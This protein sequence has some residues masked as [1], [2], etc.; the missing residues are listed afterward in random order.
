MDYAGAAEALVDIALTDADESDR[1]DAAGALASA[2]S[3]EFASS[4]LGALRRS[5]SGPPRP[6]HGGRWFAQWTSAVPLAL[7]AGLANLFLHGTALIAIRRYRIGIALLVAEAAIVAALASDSGPGWIAWLLAVT[8]LVGCWLPVKTLIER[9]SRLETRLGTFPGVLA[10]G[11][12][13]GSAFTLFFLVH[14]LAHLFAG[15]TRTAIRIFGLQLIAVVCGGLWYVDRQ[16]YGLTRVGPFYQ[17]A[18]IALWAAT[19]LWDVIPVAYCFLIAPERELARQRRRD[20]CSK[21][22]ANVT[23][24]DVLLE[25]AES[26]D[27]ADRTWARSVVRKCGDCVAPLFWV[28]VLRARGTSTPKFVDQALRNTRREETIRGIQALWSDGDPG[29]RQRYF[30][31]LA[32]SPTELSLRYLGLMRDRLS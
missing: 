1:N 17:Y 4:A 32:W 28:N 22:L 2:P 25:F 19:W 26:A 9:R 14:G 15:R 8:L 16:T 18:G 7:L 5:A 12:F 20:A 6:V 31:I 21:L 11:L 10:L 24:A 23:A 27:S 29:M 30:R 3:K 13:T